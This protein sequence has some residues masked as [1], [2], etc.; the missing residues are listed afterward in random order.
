[1]ITE[2]MGPLQPDYTS[3]SCG[4]VQELGEAKLIVFD[5]DGVFTD[6]RVYVD[7]NG[8][9]SVVCWRSDGLG[10]SKLRQLGVP[11][12]VISTEKNSVVGARCRK[13]KIDYIKSC[14]DKLAAMKQLA[15]K[16]NCSQL[17]SIIVFTTIQ[18]ALA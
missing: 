15:Q 10:L 2:N 3:L 4:L 13:L 17:R 7:Q 1:M 8:T 12:W 18:T 9:E 11:V 16:Y 6:N 5:F 14:D